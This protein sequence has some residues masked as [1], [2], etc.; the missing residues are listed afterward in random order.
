LATISAFTASRALQPQAAMA[1]V[2]RHIESV[3]FSGRLVIGIGWHGS[4]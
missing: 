3:G 1:L 2:G 4:G